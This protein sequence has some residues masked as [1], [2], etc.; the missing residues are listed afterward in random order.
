MLALE[1]YGKALGHT[2]KVY[3]CPYMWV[4]K[5]CKR[6]YM[7][8]LMCVRICSLVCVFLVTYMFRMRLSAIRRCIHGM[9]S[10]L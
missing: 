6:P 1:R 9:C 3:I 5:A 2:F 10:L 8:V 7:C 4:S